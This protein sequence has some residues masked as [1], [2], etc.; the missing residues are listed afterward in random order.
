MADGAGP[1]TCTNWAVVPHQG[2]V[3]A[4]QNVAPA[5]GCGEDE[6]SVDADQTSGDGEGIAA[7]LLCEAGSGNA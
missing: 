5:V 7:K 3:V 1:V 4:L 2:A 6:S